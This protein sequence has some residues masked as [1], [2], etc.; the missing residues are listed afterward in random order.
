MTEERDSF[1]WQSVSILVPLKRL[2]LLWKWI[3]QSVLSC[4]CEIINSSHSFRSDCIILS[5]FLW[6]FLYRE[7]MHWS[8]RVRIFQFPLQF[9]LMINKL[10]FWFYRSLFVN[11]SSVNFVNFSNLSLT[12]RAVFKCSDRIGFLHL[13]GQSC[14]IRYIRCHPWKKV[15]PVFSVA[16]A[17]IFHFQ[18]VCLLTYIAK[19]C[20]FC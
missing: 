16:N 14:D 17:Y 8:F 11:C 9:F 1:S 10:T 5:S 6:N 2:F 18:T 7:R 3:P 19:S 12:L 13:K 20:L 15:Y 4:G